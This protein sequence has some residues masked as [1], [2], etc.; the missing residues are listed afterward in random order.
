MKSI[1]VEIPSGRELQPHEV[2]S[3]MTGFCSWRRFAEEILRDAG[4]I[5]HNERV[6]SIQI[7][8]DG[9]T[10]RLTDQ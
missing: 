7:S 6:T 8:A 2:T 3:S 1:H 5:R 9:L 4:E 10:F